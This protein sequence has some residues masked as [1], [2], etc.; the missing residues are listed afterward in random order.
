MA[1]ATSPTGM[2]TKNAHRQLRWSTNRPPT[3]GP[4]P[5]ANA[6]ITPW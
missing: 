1:I 5:L 2:L 3:I 6:K 4:T